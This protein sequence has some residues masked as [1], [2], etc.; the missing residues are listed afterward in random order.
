[1]EDNISNK[2]LVKFVAIILAAD[3]TSN[4]PV[5]NESGVVCKA[6]TPICGTPMII[7]VIDALQAS[8][9]IK[10]IILC[11]PPESSL[12]A[13][14]ELEQKITNSDVTWVPN[15]NSPSKSANRGIELIDEKDP[16]FLTTADHALLTSEIINY[17]LSES[18]KSDSDATVGL[19]NHKNIIDT[20]PGMKRTVLKFYDGNFCGCN[21]YAFLNS[22]GRNLVPF[23]EKAEGLRKQPWRLVGEILGPIAILLYILRISK[24]NQALN[25]VSARAGARSQGIIIPYVNAGVDVDKA[26]D[27]VL[28]ESVLKEEKII[29]HK[30]IRA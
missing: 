17:F 21:L 2:R 4:D 5:S 23:W 3:R 22:R 19:V 12:C 26:E 1:L 25:A 10:N 27:I 16:V 8:N 30:N 24:L 29:S 13:C 7:R 28:V 18:S 14:P 15:L 9:M 6:F 20:F 11:G